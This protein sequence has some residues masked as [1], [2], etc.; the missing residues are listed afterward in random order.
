MW[1]NGGPKF[2]ALTGEYILSFHRKKQC[3][4]PILLGFFNSYDLIPTEEGQLNN[5][6]KGLGPIPK[7]ALKG[8]SYSLVK[9]C[10]NDKHAGIP[11]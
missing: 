8:R 1:D 9:N 6:F 3:Y 2:S 11:R 4:K 5:A 10:L 7:I